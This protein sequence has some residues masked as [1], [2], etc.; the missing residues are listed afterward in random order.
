MRKGVKWRD[1]LSYG[2]EKRKSKIE[3]IMNGEE[4]GEK[5]VCG[6]GGIMVVRLGE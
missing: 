3:K 6:M 5:I 4:G 1:G 2:S